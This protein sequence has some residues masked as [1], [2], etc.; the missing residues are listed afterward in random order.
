MPYIMEKWPGGYIVVT[1]AT[2]VHHSLK[3]IS[4][5]KAEAQLRVLEMIEK[6]KRDRR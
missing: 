6:A 2:G 1:K 4:K 5:R 3:P